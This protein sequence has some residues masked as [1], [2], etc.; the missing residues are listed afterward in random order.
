MGLFDRPEEEER[1]DFEPFAVDGAEGMTCW[2]SR[3]VLEKL[4]KRAPDDEGD[5]L[6]HVQG[7]GRYRFRFIETP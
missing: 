5:Y 1:G 3:E 2:I 7:L 6:F 4:K